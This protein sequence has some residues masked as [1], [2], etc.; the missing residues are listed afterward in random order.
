MPQIASGQLQTYE[1]EERLV[2]LWQTLIFVY[3][4][5]KLA[6]QTTTVASCMAYREIFSLWR[7]YTFRRYITVCPWSMDLCSSET[8]V[9][10]AQKRQ[11]YLDLCQISGP[12]GSPVTNESS[13]ESRSPH[14]LL[15]I[16][17]ILYC[18]QGLRVY[19]LGSS[20]K[21][22]QLY[23]MHCSTLLKH[24][25]TILKI[26]CQSSLLLFDCPPL[27]LCSFFNF[28]SPLVS[29]QRYIEG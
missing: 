22:F 5:C 25:K 27:F 7:E 17:V 10:C 1:M 18:G 21:G 14:P 19:R 8:V 12:V 29:F 11:R 3:Q 20:Q 13:G 26:K 15:Q 2:E 6:A 4:H 16:Y 9:M 28:I 24:R 23:L